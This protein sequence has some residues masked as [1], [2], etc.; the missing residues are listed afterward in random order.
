MKLAQSY[1]S[2]THTL[3][4][5]LMHYRYYITASHQQMC[6]RFCFVLM[7]TA[8]MSNARSSN[9]LLFQFQFNFRT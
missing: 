8:T 4:I 3:D 9:G 5:D 7:P 2:H 1:Y 6:V